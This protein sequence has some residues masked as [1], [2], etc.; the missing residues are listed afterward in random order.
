MYKKLFAFIKPLV[1][2]FLVFAL[3]VTLVLGQAGGALAAGR[4]GGRIGGGNFRAPSRTYA[5]PS[6]TYTPPG[7]GY[8]PGGGF[9]FPFIVPVFGI[10]GGF[11][12]LFSI[13]LFISIASFLVRSFRRTGEVDGY[14]DSYGSGYGTQTV[15]IAQLQ[16]GLLAGARSLQADLNRLASTANT[17]SSE[18]LTQVLQE[19][20]LSLLR[21]PEYWVY[22]GSASQQTSLPAAEGMFNRLALT[23][24]SKFTS[25]S[26]SNVNNQLR[27]A[28]T[29]GE[30][31]AAG[32]ELATPDAPG[33]YIIATILVAT[34]G[35]LQLPAVNSTEDVRRAL[36]QIGAIPSDQLLAVEVLWSP[37]AEGDVLT[38]DDVI[39]EYPNLKVV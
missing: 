16:V 17:G 30:L 25:E 27:Q 35:K 12:G 36:S 9:G 15:S 37:Q 33:E 28:A 7:G 19:T 11:G 10:G 31:P 6:R 23:E 5:P 29:S 4:S 26:V 20:T 22:A 21:H 8:Y 3:V 39:S 38:S 24:R 2:P 34:Q 13:L 18:G 14:S 32:G 1:K